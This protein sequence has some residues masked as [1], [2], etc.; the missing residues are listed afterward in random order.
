MVRSKSPAPRRRGTA[1]QSVAASP[2]DVMPWPWVLLSL[3]SGGFGPVNDD[4]YAVG[5]GI[6]SFGCEA[7]VMT[8][9]RDSQ[10]FCDSLAEVVVAAT[11][12]PWTLFS[13]L[14]LSRSRP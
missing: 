14:L 13:P 3:A 6:R 1:K 12:G 9:G 11:P 4:C 10:G 2:G 7:R 8:Y 5:Y